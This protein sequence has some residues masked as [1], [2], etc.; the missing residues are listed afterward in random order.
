[1]ATKKSPPK[2]KDL[3]L[4]K[5]LKINLLV[6]VVMAVLALVYMGRASGELSIAH[7]TKDALLS[8]T[9]TVFAPASHHLYDV[10]YRWLVWWIVLGSCIMPAL[11]LTKLAKQYK[12]GIKNK[13]LA[14]RWLE[15]ALV[16]P[17]MVVVAA[18]LSGVTDLMAVKLAAVL[19]IG[20][21]YLGWLS[22]QQNKSAAKPDWSAFIG[23]FGALAAVVL[24]LAFSAVST[25]VF[26]D[27]RASWFVYAI[28][29]VLVFGMGMSL[30]NQY[31]SIKRVKQWANYQWAER[32]YLVGSLVVRVAFVAILIYALKK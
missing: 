6:Y 28:Y 31:N 4:S 18:M 1:M 17:A 20:A 14:Y 10:E 24:L 9:K 22:E 5:N 16:M 29:G 19:V 12:D 8:Q 3:D 2:V 23:R 26:G 27:L 21:S 13:V 32:S 15:V 25:V 30:F 7:L 11:Y